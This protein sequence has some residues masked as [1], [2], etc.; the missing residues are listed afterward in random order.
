MILPTE[1]SKAPPRDIDYNHELFSKNRK[2]IKSIFIGSFLLT[3]LVAM[4]FF[5]K[6]GDVVAGVI[7]GFG[8]TAFCELF[9]LAIMV[10][11]KKSVEL[12]RNGIA[13]LGTV[14]SINAPADKQGNAYFILK[15]SYADK[16]GMTFNGNVAMI[17]KATEA[18]KKAGDQITILYMEDKP[19]TFAIYSPGIGITMSRSKRSN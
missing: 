17:G 10:N 15:V 4:L 6:F 3:P 9:A 13:T 19:E 7:W 18:D 2:K 8:L 11:T 5:W 14:D 16:L 1:L 12:F